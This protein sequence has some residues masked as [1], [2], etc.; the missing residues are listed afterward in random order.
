MLW[1]LAMAALIAQAAA[2]HGMAWPNGARAAI[3][4]TYDDAAPSQLDHAVPALDRAGLKGTFFLSN[5][6]L[7]DVA[8]WKAV[9]ASGHELA[10]HTLNHPCLAGTFAMPRRQQLENYT[11]ESVLQE[12][13]QQNVVLAALDGQREHGFAVPC[14]QTLAGGQD[15]LEPLRRSKL[16]TYSRSADE[17][18][19]DLRRDAASFDLMRLPGRAFTSPAAAAE[20]VEFAEKAAQSDG[21]AVYVFHGVGGDHLSVTAD[22]H[23]RFVDWLAARRQ[24]YW[25]ATMR[26]VV[27]WIAEHKGTPAPSHAGPIVTI[28]SG[29]LQGFA[30]QPTAELSA[31]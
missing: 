30:V 17:T 11:P 1:H 15:Y 27:Q 2:G 7:A 25:I 22:D 3:V 4:L 23:G 9:A 5:V 31:E 8:R 18:D 16:V 19:D 14:G 28:D 6:R 13:S 24:T 12:V 29:K 10:N 21:L 26:D 20:M